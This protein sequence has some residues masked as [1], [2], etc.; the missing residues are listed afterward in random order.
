MPTLTELR[1]ARAIAATALRDL[2]AQPDWGAQD[3]ER[4]ERTDAEVQRLDKRLAAAQRASQVDA[5]ALVAR[6]EVVIA[7]AGAPLPSPGGVIDA[8]GRRQAFLA[9]MRGGTEGL[10]PELRAHVQSRRGAAV[11]ARAQ[12][13]GTSS[14]GGYLVEQ[15]FGDAIERAMLTF[16]GML[17]VSTR[18]PTATGADLLIPTINDTGTSGSIVAENAQLSEG[19]ATFAQIS[20][21]SYMYTSG[22]ILVSQQ[23][24]QD[25]VFPLDA[26]IADLLGERLGRILNTHFTTGTGS[27]QP[28]GIATGSTA[29]V[30]GATGQTT[31]VT[32]DDLVD[33]VHSV[34]PAYRAK[35]RWQMRDASVGKIRKLKDSQNLPLWQPSMTAGDPDMLLGYP[36]TVNNDVAAMAASAKSIFF[37]DF[38]K[39]FW[40]DVRGITMTRLDERYADY[41]QVG[42]LAFSRAGG[43]LVNG[44]T[45]PVK[46]YV[47]SAS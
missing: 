35:A 16:G 10:A 17:G 29:G 41:L 22:L 4:F 6:G 11:E 24:M 46:H 37:G 33:L 2:V 12:S 5:E 45:N 13:V 18:I 47:N 44:G 36:I 21:P 14:A 32:Y 31:T 39:Y 20:I 26:F 30:T 38:S 42:F 19:A 40:R 34:D 8:E 23:L 25:S 7:P 1:E 15:E 28:H 9:W 43:R 27:S 3:E